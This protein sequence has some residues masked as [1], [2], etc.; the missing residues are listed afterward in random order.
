M[1]VFHLIAPETWEAAVSA[2]EYAPASMQTEGFVH[3]S[4]EHQLQATANRHYGGASELMAV[5]FESSVFGDDLVVE[6][7]SGHGEFPHVY[8]AISPGEASGVVGLI[9]RG[10]AW[11]LGDRSGG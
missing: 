4:F 1:K 3:M 6:D 11:V 10:G 5:V 8:R 7:T 9:R 2:G